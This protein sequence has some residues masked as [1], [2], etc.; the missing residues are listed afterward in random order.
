MTINEYATKWNKPE[1]NNFAVACADQ[2]TLE[3]LQNADPDKTD[4]ETWGLNWEEWH[5]AIGAAI[6]ERTNAIL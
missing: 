1:D 3:E 4:M 2:N 6:E 5:D